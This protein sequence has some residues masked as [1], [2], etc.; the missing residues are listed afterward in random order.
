MITTEQW[1]AMEQRLAKSKHTATAVI[2][3][4]AAE[5]E[6]SLQDQIIKDIRGRGWWVVFSRMDLPTTN[7][8]GTPDLIC[9]ADKGRVL[10]IEAKSKHGKLRP[11]QLGVKLALEKLGHTVHIVR[12]FA[13]YLTVVNSL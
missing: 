12:G 3:D 6:S 2:P 7:P 9:F 1:W 5:D 13:E 8:L 10:I 11:A 4:D